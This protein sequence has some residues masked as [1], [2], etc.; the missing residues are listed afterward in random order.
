MAL[1]SLET[2]ASNA[3][4]ARVLADLATLTDSSDSINKRVHVGENQLVSQCH[5][6]KI[7]K[8]KNNAYP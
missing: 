2:W 6:T 4:K 3:S 8:K 5:I 7:L 1:R